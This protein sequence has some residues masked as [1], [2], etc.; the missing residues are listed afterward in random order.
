MLVVKKGVKITKTR[1]KKNHRC[2]KK[3]EEEI[4]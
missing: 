2:F 1:R 3:E 4:R